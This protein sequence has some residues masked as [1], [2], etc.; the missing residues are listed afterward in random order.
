[1]T[2]SARATAGHTGSYRRRLRNYLLDSRFQLKYAG[3]LVVVALVISS[4]MGGVL[5]ATTR[6]MVGESAKVVDESRK[7]AEESRKVSSVT[8]MNVRD[9]AS[10]SPDLV[11]EFEKEADAYD[12]ALAEHEKAVADQQALLVMRQR[13]MIGSLVGGLSLMVVAIGLFGIYF[14]HR[15]AGPV[16]KM[17]RLLRQVGEGDLR[18]EARLRRG[19]ELKGFFDEF[20]RMVAGLRDLDRRQLEEVE[21]A[22]QALERGDRGDAAVS[23]QRVRRVIR[24]AIGE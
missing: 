17:K 14:T 2:T 8:R 11:A 18:V 24:D 5:Y 6:A 7:A 13:L 12:R 1:M 20:T 15:V 19:D 21:A 23:L 16:H 10:E 9:L 4:I 22:I 3:F